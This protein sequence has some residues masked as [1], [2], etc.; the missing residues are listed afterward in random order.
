MSATAEV[1]RLVMALRSDPRK[2]YRQDRGR[3]D[4]CEVFELHA[5]WNSVESPSV[6]HACEQGMLGCSDCRERLIRIG[7]RRPE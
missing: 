1:R 2:I 6:R 3:P 5:A 4:E 7:I